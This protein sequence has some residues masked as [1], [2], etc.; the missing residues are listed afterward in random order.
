M[1]VVGARVGRQLDETVNIGAGGML[2]LSSSAETQ[3]ADGFARVT[4]LLYLGPS[5]ELRDSLRG[6]V[7]FL[8]RATVAGGVAGIEESTA[9]SVDAGSAFLVGVAPEAGVLVRV[10]RILQLTGTIGMFHGW[11]LDGGTSIITG[12]M[13]SAGVRLIR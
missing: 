4:S 11:R 13:A 7:G 1:T 10:S 5:I 2:M 8:L 9:G 3:H 12:P 6:R